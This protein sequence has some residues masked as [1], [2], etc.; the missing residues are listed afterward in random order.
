MTNTETPRPK[1][2]DLFRAAAEH[3]YP[4]WNPVTH[5]YRVMYSR[6]SSYDGRPLGET[7]VFATE[8]EARA[9]FDATMPACAVG[10]VYIHLAIN[11][12]DWCNRGRWQMVASRGRRGKKSAK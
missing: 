10:R 4:R 8:A 2:V 6:P 11:G 7:A 5:P 1:M 3:G 12:E 9:A